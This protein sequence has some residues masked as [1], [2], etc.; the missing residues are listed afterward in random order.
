MDHIACIK[1]NSKQISDLSVRAKPVRHLEENIVQTF[2][3]EFGKEFLYSVEAWAAKKNRLVT[4][5]QDR[6]SQ[7]IEK[8]GHGGTCIYNPRIWGAEGWGGVRRETEA[9]KQRIP[10][11]PGF[12][13]KKNVLFCFWGR[14]SLCV[15][16]YPET[17]SV[18]QAGHEIRAP[19]ASPS[20]ILGLK[21]CTTIPSKNK[22][23]S[24]SKNIMNLE[25]AM[26]MP[27]T[28]ASREAEEG[29]LWVRG[30]PGLQDESFVIKTKI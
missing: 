26:H 8:V 25:V 27:L 13:V 7:N 22:N 3:T 30:C 4:L 6:T 20:Q 9:R 17:G 16:G 28:P 10:G 1:T 11:E 5:H 12:V 24:A 14:F 29:R 18:D 19:P 15:S 2:M 21:R 23:I